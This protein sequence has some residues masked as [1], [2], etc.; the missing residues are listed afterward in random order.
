MPSSTSPA[1]VESPEPTPSPTFE[2]LF[3]TLTETS[4]AARD[5]RESGS[6]QSSRTLGN[7]VER[8]REI[9]NAQDADRALYLEHL[10]EL[11]DHE[12][13]VR[14][15]RARLLDE[16]LRRYYPAAPASTPSDEPSRLTGLDNWIPASSE[17]FLGV[18][19]SA[20]ARY[21][22]RDPCNRTVSSKEQLDWCTSWSA[23]WRDLGTAHEAAVTCDDATMRRLIVRLADEKAS[24][25]DK[26]AA[27]EINATNQQE[28]R[29]FFETLPRP[30]YTWSDQVGVFH[31]D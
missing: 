31:V 24:R 16:M 8:A 2:R 19:R 9:R 12:Q 22:W 15:R 4:P 13:R 14:P 23:L 17:S 29:V 30:V 26:T 7:L 3:D 25:Q 18:D 10:R 27:A 6:E 1:P 28:W 5:A 20:V 21:N 11:R